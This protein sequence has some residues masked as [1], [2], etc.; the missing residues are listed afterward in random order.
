[1]PHVLDA[2]VCGIFGDEELEQVFESIDG[3]ED[4]GRLESVKRDA[5][6]AG[7]NQ[8][9]GLDTCWLLTSKGWMKSQ[10]QGVY[11]EKNKAS[12]LRISSREITCVQYSEQL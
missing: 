3:A 5:R 9:A 2:S 8:E 4:S 10:R 6:V 12:I 7:G 1:M 11:L